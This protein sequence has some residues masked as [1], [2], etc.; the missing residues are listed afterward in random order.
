MEMFDAESFLKEKEDEIVRKFLTLRKSELILL[1]Q[2]LQLEIR[3][4]MRKFEIQRV[5]LN[6]LVEEEIVSEDK[7]EI[8]EVM[9]IPMPTVEMRKLELQHKLEL[10]KIASEE[11]TRLE[12]IANEERARQERMVEEE[13]TKQE[14]LELEKIKIANEERARQERMMEEEKTRLEKIASEEKLRHH[15]LEQEREIE[16]AKLTHAKEI[17]EMQ[18]QAGQKISFSSQPTQNHDHTHFNVAQWFHA[19]PK[20]RENAVED[21]FVSF[22]KMAHRLKWPYEYWTTLLQHV[23]VGK[24]LEVYNQLDVEGSEKFENVKEAILNAYEKV[25]EAYRQKFRSQ[26]KTFSQTYV[27]FAHVKQRSFDQWCHAMNVQKDYENLRQIVLIEEFKNNLNVNLRMY[28]DERRPKDIN[29]AAWL[30]D[31]YTL[32]HQT[33]FQSKQGSNSHRV[34]EKTNFPIKSSGEKEKANQSKSSSSKPQSSNWSSSVRCSFC[35]KPGHILSD[36]FILKRRQE[37]Q[38]FETQKSG[39]VGHISTHNSTPNTVTAVKDVEKHLIEFSMESFKPFIHDGSISLSSDFSNSTPIKILRDTGASQSLLLLNTLPFSDSSYTGT[40]VLIKGVNSKDFESIP[41]HSIHITSK[42]VSGPVTIGVRESLP[43]RDI[44]LLLG[45]DLAGDRVI[46]NPLITAKP[47]VDQTFDQSE[48]DDSHLYPAC[49][50]TRA[51]SK[52]ALKDNKNIDEFVDLSDTFVGQVLK[53]K[54]SELTKVAETVSSDPFN[55][56]AHESLTNDMRSDLIKNQHADKELHT[57]FQRS[58]NAD[59]AKLESEGY[60]TNNGVLMRKWRPPQVPAE[61]DWAEYHQIVVPQSYRPEILSMAHETPLAG[62]LGVNKTYNK[63]AKHF[64]WPRMKGDVVK[65]CRSCHTCQVANV[66]N[67]LEKVSEIARKNLKKAQNSMA[68]QYD[69]HAV[70]RSFVPGDKVLAIFPVTGK[71]LQARFHGPYQIHKKISEVNYVVLTPDRRKEKQLCHINMLKPYIEREDCNESVHPISAVSVHEQSDD[72]LQDIGTP[73]KLDNSQVLKD[74]NVKVSHLSKTEQQDMKEILSEYNHL[75]PDIPTRTNQLHHDVDIGNAQPIKQHS[76]RLNPEKAKY[77]QKEIQ[78]LLENDLIEPSKSNWSSPCILVPKPDGSYRLCTDYRKVNTVTKT[79]TYPIPRIDDCIDKIGNARYVSKFDL[80][81]GFWQVPL[82]ERAKEI[83]AF[84]T[85]DGLFQYKV[86]PFGMKNSPATFQR[87]INQVISGLTGC[88]AYIDDVIVYSET[89]SEHVEIMCKL[90]EKL[91]DAKLTV[92]LCKCEFGK[93]TVTFLGHVV[94]QGNVKPVVAK[95]KAICEFPVP[96][97]KKQLMRFLGMAGY[98]RKFCPNFSTIAEPLTRLLSKRVKF[99]WSPECEIAFQK[100]KAILESSPVLV[101]PNFSKL[102]KLVVDASEVASGS[103]LLQEDEVGVDHP[104]CYFSKKFNKSQLN[105]STIEK[106][107]LALV[108]AIKHFEVYLSSS[109]LPICV[110]S[111]HNPLVFINKMKNSNQRLL[112]WSLMLQEYN[113]EVR[114]IRGKDNVI[115]D[116]LSRC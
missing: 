12:K 112:R 7:I 71:P 21:F 99:T 15:K 33:N 59:E 93:A 75:F 13:K 35:K 46:I 38:S 28:I 82:T 70:Q 77:L 50:I 115:A 18:L 45:N 44:Q 89:W 39:T 58:V 106:E 37:Q 86:M 72:E 76:Y 53:E 65:F 81:K 11:K 42:F 23:L 68:E 113:I 29:E 114:H 19:V 110:F 96:K 101:A 17:A 66:K 48:Q 80:L 27:E 90:F 63:M 6:Y 1:A 79:D 52:K 49:A 56:F 84:V 10:Q 105:Y 4:A 54:T 61:D 62:H 3:S 92:N 74:I 36:C 60:Y 2:N 14:K 31:E 20:F 108:L 91:S 111:D 95:V 41:L 116:C 98:Y 88:D 64:Y 25:P 8:P 51:M 43:Y 109:S 104:V 73:V 26:R 78:Y 67:K 34:G 32:I 22:E 47:C 94:G 57:M 24:A 16:L 40:N 102:F 107:C 85:P 30:A 83:S 103:A 87:L 97:G 55:D 9:P 5:I 69:K 100:L